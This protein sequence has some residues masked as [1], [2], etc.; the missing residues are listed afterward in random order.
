MTTLTT[1]VLTYKNI[2]QHCIDYLFLT[3]TYIT[4]DA[5]FTGS[6]IW[7]DSYKSDSKPKRR[8][9]TYQKEKQKNSALNEP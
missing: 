1:T 8:H 7:G 4:I 5:I 6:Q 2:P 9:V 3:Q